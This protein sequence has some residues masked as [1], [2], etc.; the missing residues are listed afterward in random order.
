VAFFLTTFFTNYFYTMKRLFALSVAIFSLFSVSAQ[1]V[2]PSP[3][4]QLAPNI[5][6]G[7]MLNTSNT[8]VG[9]RNDT[10][11]DGTALYLYTCKIASTGLPVAYPLLEGGTLSILVSG[12]KVSG[13]AA[14]SISLQ[15]SYDGTNWA[16]VRGSAQVPVSTSVGTVTTTYVNQDAFTI[17]DVSTQQSYSWDLP[18]FGAPY[19]RVKVLG[20]GTQTSSWKAW[21]CFKRKED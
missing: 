5:Y 16:P 3:I 17:T 12:I 18:T 6:R 1:V 10:A 14:G 19:Y 11:T 21:F 4:T 9:Q 13:T 7:Q 15:E 8:H 2:Y 20:S